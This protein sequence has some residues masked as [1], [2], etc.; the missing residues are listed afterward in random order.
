MRG[1]ASNTVAIVGSGIGGLAAACVIAASG[2]RVTVYERAAV[3]GGKL[4]TVS[5]GG[6]DVDSGPTV[7]T[8]KAIFEDIFADCG[9]DFDTMVRTRPA[10]IL[11]R[12]AW[13]AD[14]RLDL[15]AD[16]SRSA[17]AIGSLCGAREARAFTEF[18]EAARRSWAVLESAFVRRPAPSLFGLASEGLRRSSLGDL[19][20]IQPFTTLAHALA[21]HFRDPRLQQLFG[22]YA[23]YCG[24]SPFLSPATLM[25][26]AH[27]EQAGVWTLDGGMVRLVD[28]FVALASTL[29]VTF[30]HGADVEEIRIDREGVCGAR[31]AGGETID[32]DAVIFNGDVSALGASGLLGTMRGRAPASVRPGSRSLS[33]MTWSMLAKPFGFPLERHNVFFSGDYRREFESLLAQGRIPDDPTVYICAQDRHDGVQRESA[34]ERILC[35]INAPANGDTTCY[36]DETIARCL[37]R[38]TASLDR[39]GLSIEPVSEPVATTPE[40]FARLFPAT[41]GAL[42]GRASHGWAAS[43]RRA[44]VKTRIPGLYCAGGSVHPGP[45]IPMAALS[46]RMAAQCLIADSRSPRRVALVPTHRATGKG[47]S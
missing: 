45:G 9:A 16:A 29:G 20:A 37:S 46:G 14:Q 23:T 17:D 8:L 3:S 36:D 2:H 21:K 4:R 47:L 12:H 15:H 24:S 25:L 5:C 26:V 11:A 43:F 27:V 39:C 1:L 7:F 35:L 34:P 33:A 31:L 32:C 41:G 38:V 22:R 10:T 13:G 40:T 30:R 18:C 28:A 19:R 44:G 42:Y 6:S